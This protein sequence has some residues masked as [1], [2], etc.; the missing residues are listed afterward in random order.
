MSEPKSPRLELLPLRSQGRSSLA[1]P[2]PSDPVLVSASQREQTARRVRTAVLALIETVRSG[3][4]HDAV[5]SFYAPDVALGR[6]ALAPMFGLDTPATRRFLN[7]N[8]DANWCGFEVHGVGVNGDT[9]FI[10]Y[11][12][13]FAARNGERIR[14]DQV[15]VARW[16]DGVI[17]SECLLPAR[18]MR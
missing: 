11:S 7:R 6:G 10:E 2:T 1:V 5:R 14:V 16:R 13:E 18:A 12:L 4:I 8:V 9:S 3:R 15:A 17:V